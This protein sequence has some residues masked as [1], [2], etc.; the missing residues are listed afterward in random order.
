M[1]YQAFSD[2]KAK[3]ARHTLTF[4]QEN[5]G[6]SSK[7][8]TDWIYYSKVLKC[9][10]VICNNNEA[11]DWYKE[12][13]DQVRGQTFRGWAKEEQVTTCVKFFVPLGLES[14]SSIEYLEALCIMYASTKGIPWTTLKEYIHHSKNTRI[15][16]ATIPADIFTLIQTK[17]TETSVGSGVWKAIGY[18]GPLKLTVKMTSDP[19]THQNT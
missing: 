4:L 18:M 14:I 12:A 10:I 3:L 17:G 13:I 2:L 8:Y 6:L 11:L 15:I 5:L 7:T 9:G 19:T 1:A 16:I